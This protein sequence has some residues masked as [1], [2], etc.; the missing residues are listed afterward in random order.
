VGL[1]PTA[2]QVADAAPCQVFKLCIDHD[3]HTII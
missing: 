2:H 3:N 1:Q